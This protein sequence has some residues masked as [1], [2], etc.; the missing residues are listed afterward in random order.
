M[1]NNTQDVK[2]ILTN[3]DTELDHLLELLKNS[4]EWRSDTEVM[5]KF[6]SMYEKNMEI[7]RLGISEKKEKKDKKQQLMEA[8]N[9][10]KL[11]DIHR[12]V[13]DHHFDYYSALDL[14]KEQF[15]FMKEFNEDYRL[16]PILDLDGEKF[17]VTLRCVC[18]KKAGWHNIFMVIHLKEEKQEEQEEE[19]QVEITKSDNAVNNEQKVFNFSKG[20]GTTFVAHVDDETHVKIVNKLVE[21]K[22]QIHQNIKEK[23][24][25]I[26]KVWNKVL[27]RSEQYMDYLTNMQVK[28]YTFDLEI[29]D[30]SSEDKK[31]VTINLKRE[32]IAASKY[33]RNASWMKMILPYCTES[34][35]MGGGT[36]YITWLDDN[37]HQRVIEHLESKITK[38]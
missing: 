10:P 1:E 34:F 16:I 27:T 12:K 17:L 8:R 32:H 13:I 4:D 14:N 35:H 37:L 18:M 36:V 24:D 38:C 3:I 15:R 29:G 11:H 21:L 26:D 28:K 7:I 9:H 33:D 23:S 25:F 2:A 19:E 5:R 30:Q 20:R 22:D 31:T 6:I